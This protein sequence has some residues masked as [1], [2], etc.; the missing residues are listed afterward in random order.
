MVRALTLR[1]YVFSKSCWTLFYSSE[2]TAGGKLRLTLR[3][4]SHFSEP[5][6]PHTLPALAE[7]TPDNYVFIH[8]VA[9]GLLPSHLQTYIPKEGTWSYVFASKNYSAKACTVLRKEGI[10][11]SAP[12][13]WN[14]MLNQSNL[15]E[16][17]SL[18]NSSREPLKTLL[19][20][21][22]P[23]RYKTTKTKTNHSLPPYTSHALW[24]PFL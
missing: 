9:L 22:F 4:Q 3:P 5:L 19:L 13:L 10:R 14:Q 24:N 8:K 18:I 17:L 21:R 11:F 12:S 7:W 23:L 20:E 15:N 1:Q 2:P 16:L 6:N